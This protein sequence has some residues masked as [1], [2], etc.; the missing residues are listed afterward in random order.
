MTA[1]QYY[2][3]LKDQ[4]IDVFITSIEDKDT[5]GQI[6]NIKSNLNVWSTLTH[7]WQSSRM[8]HNAAQELDISCAHLLFGFYRSSFKSLRLALEMICGSIYYSAFNLEYTEWENGTKDLTWNQLICNENG[9]FSHRFTNAYFSELKDEREHFRCLAKS[10][11]RT[12]S[13]MV[14]GNNNTWSTQDPKIEFNGHLS[15]KYTESVEIISKILNFGFCLK[16][17]KTF[18]EKEKEEIESYINESIGHITHIRKELGG[19][20]DE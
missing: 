13:E 8:L 14:H 16:Y 6:T 20:V 19:P 4:S 18:N 5:L 12:L 3:K 7:Q 15:Q 1:E 2:Q 17:L 11:Y 10:L 9:V